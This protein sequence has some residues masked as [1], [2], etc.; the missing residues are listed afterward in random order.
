[1]PSTAQGQS[2]L[3]PVGTRLLH[4]GP[5]KTGTTALQSALY[6][7]RPALVRQGVRHAGSS[8]NPASAVA[9]VIGR[10]SRFRGNIVPS[11]LAWGRLARDIRRAREPRV[12]VSSEFFA[13]AEPE[14]IRRVVR[15]LDPSRI[16]VVVTLRP[17]ARIIPSQ[18]QQYAQAGV[19]AS[20]EAWLEAMLGDRRT[21]MTPSFWRRHRHDRLIARWAEVVGPE[22]MTVIALDDRD[23]GMVLRV[24]EQLTGLR[25]GTLVAPPDLVNRSMTMPEIEAVRAFNIAFRAEGLGRDLHSKVMGFGAA[26]FMK[27]RTP[28]PSEPQ[29]ESPQWALDRVAVI[30]REMVDSIAASGVR[31]VGDLE[32]LTRVPQPDPESERQTSP[33]IPLDVVARM[34]MG[35]VLASGMGRARPQ[36]RAAV[37]SG[38]GTLRPRSRQAVEP[39]AVAPVPT[40]VLAGVVVGRA[41]VAIATRVRTARRRLPLTAHGLRLRWRPDRPS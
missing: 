23:H 30:A 37:S 40:Y 9:S 34:S 22:R 8:R 13:D 39:P 17:L 2:L 5:H 16:H 6:D 25:E 1:M 41:R 15:D 21:R 4:I 27:L 35:I 33:E 38:G 7:A 3:L 14:A 20:Y 24:F 28:D 32:G 10:R 31:V 26:P 12:V 29:V 19:T 18:W 36:V 11:A